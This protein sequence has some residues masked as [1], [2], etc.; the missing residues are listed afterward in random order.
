MHVGQV[1]FPEGDDGGLEDAVIAMELGARSITSTKKP[2]KP[3]G[4][5]CGT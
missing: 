3:S 5:I 2:S 4:P 1:D